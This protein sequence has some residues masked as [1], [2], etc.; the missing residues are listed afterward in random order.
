MDT[1]YGENDGVSRKPSVV[2]GAGKLKRQHLGRMRG[3]SN[4]S[5]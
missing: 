5:F 4:Q 2:I 3:R 1:E